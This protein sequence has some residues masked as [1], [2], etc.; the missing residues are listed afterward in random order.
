MTIAH[1]INHFMS[2]RSLTPEYVLSLKIAKIHCLISTVTMEGMMMD[3]NLVKNLLF[4][5][6]HQRNLRGTK[7]SNELDC[8]SC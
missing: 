6:L 7:Q 4:K 8:K 3:R 2:R 5:L 1:A